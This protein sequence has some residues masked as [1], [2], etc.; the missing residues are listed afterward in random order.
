MYVRPIS[1]PR[2]TSPHAAASAQQHRCA[3]L[4]AHISMHTM[5]RTHMACRHMRSHRHANASGT[6][7]APTSSLVVRRRRAV[8]ASA[9][10]QHAPF[11][12]LR[13]SWYVRPYWRA[14]V[15]SAAGPQRQERPRQV[16]TL[17]R[18][19]HPALRTRTSASTLQQ[20]VAWAPSR[21][22]YPP[23]QCMRT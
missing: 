23:H 13:A 17:S 6:P 10:P 2:S 22:M 11:R 3:R 4:R 19:G 5:A 14:G 1:I 12:R 21:A 18:A 9:P 7:A 20:V 15:R 16:A 8:T